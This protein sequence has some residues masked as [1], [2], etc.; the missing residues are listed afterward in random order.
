MLWLAALALS[1][2]GL[3]ALDI[4]LLV[5]FAVTL[6]WF[7]IGFWN[8]TIGFLIMRFARDPAAAVTPA[9]ARI[10][11]DEPI[12]LSTA[13]LVCLR[14]EPPQRVARY[15]TPLLDGLAADPAGARFH[16]YLLSDS[17]AGAVAA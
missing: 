1:P 11:G 8:A 3:S 2:G 16:L 7:A 14:N 15:L 6:P 5:L 12:T 17:D 13:L 9:V 4:A 10:R